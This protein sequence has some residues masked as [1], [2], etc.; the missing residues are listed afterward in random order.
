[1]KKRA[2][3][4]ILFCFTI[5]VAPVF[6]ETIELESGKVIVGDI[7]QETDTAVVI[8]KPGGVF[9]SS[10]A[11]DRIKSIRPST[12]RE[13][14]REEKKTETKVYSGPN[15]QD[16][17]TEREKYKDYR[18]EQY[19]KEVELAKKAR[20]R[21]NIDFVKGMP[22]VVETTLN[23]KETAL[24]LVDTG[25]S[26]VVISQDLAG[27]LGI[28]HES[29]KE[30]ITVVLADGSTAKAI[31]ITL[32]SVQVGSSTVKNVGAAITEGTTSGREDGLLGMTFLRYFHVKIDSKENCLVLEKY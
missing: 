26:M 12:P 20:G 5:F 6:S 21:V 32:D 23:G 15:A 24:L 27:R 17:K 16:E 22:G 1:M 13:V 10:I 3:F 11:R 18:L 19:E 8:S 25:A 2:L 4:F 28:A 30:R 9:I 14:E 31:P 29:M 7:L